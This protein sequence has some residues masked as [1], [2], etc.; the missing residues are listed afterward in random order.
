MLYSQAVC[1]IFYFCTFV[2]HVLHCLWWDEYVRLLCHTLPKDLEPFIKA[3][4]GLWFIA[5]TWFPWN[6]KICI[7]YKSGA[8]LTQSVIEL[9]AD[10][11]R[12]CNTF[13]FY[14][15]QQCDLNWLFPRLTSLMRHRRIVNNSLLHHRLGIG[16]SFLCA[17]NAEFI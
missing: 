10:I 5:H 12:N 3:M 7:C 6:F 16:I 4:Y 2:R 8:Y 9:C 11:Y 17:K 1:H 15:S 13:L 14:W